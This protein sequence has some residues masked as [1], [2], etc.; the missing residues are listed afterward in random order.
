[1]EFQKHKPELT[2]PNGML[3]LGFHFDVNS[4]QAAGASSRSPSDGPTACTNRSSPSPPYAPNKTGG[5]GARSYKVDIGTA[6]LYNK[7]TGDN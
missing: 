5:A 7:Q 4:A 2:L 1:M 3:E 6:A